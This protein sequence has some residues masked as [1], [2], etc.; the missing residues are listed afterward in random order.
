MRVL[1][2][3]DLLDND[4]Y[5]FTMQYALFHQGHA[6]VLVSYKMTDRKAKVDAVLKSFPINK[7]ITVVNQLRDL[8]VEHSS[9]KWNKQDLEYIVQE[10]R[11]IV[12]DGDDLLLESYA[13]R[14]AEG[15]RVV[16]IKVSYDGVTPSL[17]VDY[18][19]SWFDTILLE[20]PF[21]AIICELVASHTTI[22]LSDADI[23]ST[24]EPKL[25]IY[26][27]CG[28]NVTEFGTR[29][30]FS[31][32]VQFLISQHLNESDMNPP[33]Y[34]SNVFLS[35]KNGTLPRGTCAHEW[36]MFYETLCRKE[37][38][39]ATPSSINPEVLVSSIATALE[40]WLQVYQSIFA[41]TDVFTT[42][43]FFL[44]YKTLS[45][46]LQ[47]RI[48]YRCDSG[49]ELTYVELIAKCL[50]RVGLWVEEH[51]SNKEI[52]FSNSLNPEKVAGIQG[53]FEERKRVGGVCAKAFMYGVGTNFTNDLQY[54]SLDLVIKLYSVD[55][56]G[57]GGGKSELERKA[58]KL[59]DVEAKFTGD[60][61]I[62][63][64]AFE[65]VS[66]LG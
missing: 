38:R 40:S 41:L 37:N 9:L 8:L 24:L 25:E 45:G 49:D 39:T 17:A 66:Q 36:F 5:K 48:Q 7:Q 46:E 27:S 14:L 13:K 32:H 44:A 61:S 10:L 56:S 42:H 57:C 4:W 34:T 65:C 30:R 31:Q 19:G 54:D 16:E 23:L 63:D 21:L 20:V 6:D 58:F 12:K 26:K 55:G 29:R 22:S 3:V 33:I 60:A 59:S 35:K 11:K 15:D 51:L 64:S 53:F 62:R 43:V 2:P 28:A 1:S 50:E 52:M 18:S 47:S